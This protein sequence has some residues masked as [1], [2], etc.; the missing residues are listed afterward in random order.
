MFHLLSQVDVEELEVW[1]TKL[2]FDGQGSLT[3][4]KLPAIKVCSTVIE[5]NDLSPL[6]IKLSAVKVSMT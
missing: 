6:P 1:Y 5:E 3:F 4:T 2:V